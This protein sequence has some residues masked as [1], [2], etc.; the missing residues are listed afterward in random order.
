MTYSDSGHGGV[1]AC[2]PGD[3]LRNG[4]RDAAGAVGEATV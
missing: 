4:G 3:D 2:A 1:H